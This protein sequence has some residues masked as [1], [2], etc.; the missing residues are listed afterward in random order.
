M[1]SGTTSAWNAGAFVKTSTSVP[2]PTE[3][4]PRLNRGF[5][6]RTSVPAMPPSEIPSQ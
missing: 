5:V 3:V 1:K 2:P 6:A 4:T